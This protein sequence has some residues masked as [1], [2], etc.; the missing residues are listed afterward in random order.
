M[1]TLPARLRFELMEKGR[2]RGG[3]GGRAKAREYAALRHGSV[4][5]START[6]A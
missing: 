6:K 4:Y 1:A 2:H 3:V 5:D